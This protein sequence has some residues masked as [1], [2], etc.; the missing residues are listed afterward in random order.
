MIQITSGCLTTKYVLSN[1]VIPSTPCYFEIKKNH[2]NGCYD[3][4][5]VC[6]RKTNARNGT[7]RE[8]WAVRLYG[9]HSDLSFNGQIHDNQQKKFYDDWGENCN[10]GIFYNPLKKSMSYFKNGKFIG[11]PFD[12]VEGELYICLEVCHK[13]SYEIVKDVQLPD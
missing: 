9:D 5:G 7:T 12:N 8:G 11:T 2:T 3:S 6:T 1:E 13:G 10:I 4:F